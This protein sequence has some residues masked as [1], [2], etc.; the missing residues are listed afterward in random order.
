MTIEIPHV[1]GN[2]RT[3]LAAL[4]IAVRQ[5]LDGRVRCPSMPSHRYCLSAHP[6]PGGSRAVCVSC[7][8]RWLMFL[9][10]QDLKKEQRSATTRG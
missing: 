4:T 7:T 5:G 1:R 8:V 3:L 6:K 2:A 9:A 10:E